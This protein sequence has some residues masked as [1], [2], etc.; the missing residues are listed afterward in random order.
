MFYNLELVFFFLMW[1]F[2]IFLSGNL[3]FSYLELRILLIW[4]IEFLLSGA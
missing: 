3:N 4:N 1:S 2:D